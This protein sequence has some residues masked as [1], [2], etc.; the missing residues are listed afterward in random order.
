MKLAQQFFELN[1]AYE[2]LLDPL[3]RQAITASVKAKE[4][5]KARFSQY[6]QK[7]KDLQNELEEREREFKRQKTDKAAEARARSAENERIVEAGRRMREKRDENSRRQAEEEARPKRDL[8]E[9][10]EDE[11]P[12]LGMPLQAFIFCIV[13]SDR[14]LLQDTSTPPSSSNSTWRPSQT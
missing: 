10:A 7:R 13:I 8:E 9:S 1:Q 14:S 4:A 6:D 2:I 12:Q 11:V 3:R 5:R